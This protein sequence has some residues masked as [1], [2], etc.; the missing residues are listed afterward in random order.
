MIVSATQ[1]KEFKENPVA[2][3]KLLCSALGRGG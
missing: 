3:L 2:A 1:E